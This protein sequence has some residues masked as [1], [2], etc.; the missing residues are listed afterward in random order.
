MVLHGLQAGMLP[1][2][3]CTS[4]GLKNASAALLLPG[5]EGDVPRYD[6]ATLRPLRSADGSA[7][8]KRR[9][10][11]LEA[12]GEAPPGPLLPSA[13]CYNCGSYGH[14]MG[15]CFR[16]RDAETEAVSLR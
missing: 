9:A 8:G 13:R 2:C 6:R 5:Q 10:A 15:Q 7:A 3:T 11:L 12:A 1:S 16:E 14:G 4:L